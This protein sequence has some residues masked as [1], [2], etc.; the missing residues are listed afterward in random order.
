MG[1]PLLQIRAK[2]LF[3]YTVLMPIGAKCLICK[4]LAMPYAMHCTVIQAQATAQAKDSYRCRP[5]VALHCA[6][7]RREAAL[8]ASVPGNGPKWPAMALAVPRLYLPIADGTA[9]A[10]ARSGEY[11]H[12]IMELFKKR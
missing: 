12:L 5:P 8:S 11:Q 2:A 10:T 9:P 7:M 4:V 1:A 6:Q 3:C